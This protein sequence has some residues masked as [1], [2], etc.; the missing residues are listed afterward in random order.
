MVHIQ[1]KFAYQKEES[2]YF[3]FPLQHVIFLIWVVDGR[4]LR[5]TSIV[6]RVYKNEL[7]ANY[8]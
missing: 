7:V 2:R 1:L 8:G 3:A 4:H 5:K 6:I